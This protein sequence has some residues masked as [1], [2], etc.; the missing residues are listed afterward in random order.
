MMIKVVFLDI[1]NTLLS[2]SGYVKEAMREGFPHFGL[3]EY[4]ESMYPIFEKINGGLWR[5]IEQKKITFEE[6][7]E[8]RWNK[9]FAALGIDF[10]GRIFEKYFRE[11]LFDSAVFEDGAKDL[12]DYLAEKY[13]LCVV[14]NGPYEQQINR[15]R[16]GEILNYFSGLYISSK[17]GTS[18]PSAEFF[19]YCFDDLHE[20]G[21]ESLAPEE[22]M[23]IGD[24]ITADIA[25]G[26]Q[27]GMQTCLYTG[28]KDKI[29]DVPEADY[30]VAKL[31]DIKKI[32]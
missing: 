12:L 4:K 5:D 9:I 7:L 18:K 17:V 3:P 25:G 24:S 27:Y 15:L 23:I 30:I 10:D 16:K 31:S 20:N 14:S 6:L 19:D 32:L 11:K 29:S 22:V 1:D 28:V 21:F 13:T 2:F 8:I 26:K